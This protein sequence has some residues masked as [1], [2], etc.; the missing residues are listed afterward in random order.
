MDKAYFLDEDDWAETL[1]VTWRFG[2]AKFLGHLHLEDKGFEEKK[3]PEL[4]MLATVLSVLLID[5]SYLQN[6]SYATDRTENMIGT[7]I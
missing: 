1:Q 5:I 6:Y 4:L 7:E 2:Q 3:P